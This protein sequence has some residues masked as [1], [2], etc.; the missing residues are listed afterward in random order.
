MAKGESLP[1][2]IGL[3][4]RIY[5]NGSRTQSG[6]LPAIGS[7][8][9]VNGIEYVVIDRE[10]DPSGYQGLTLLDRAS[11]SIIVVNR[12][13][14]TGADFATDAQMAFTTASNQ[15]KGAL[16]LGS[17]VAAL[18]NQFG[19]TAIF[20]TGHSLGGTLTQ[21]QSAYFGWQGYTFNAYGADLPH[22]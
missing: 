6:T 17:R 21:L 8:F 11:N 19:V 1:N 18:A 15:W 2:M 7:K 20:A 3:S 16:A 13:T 5:S 10:N 4:S 9:K 12:G 22:H 14:Q